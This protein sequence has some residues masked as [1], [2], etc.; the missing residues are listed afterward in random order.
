MPDDV[1]VETGFRLGVKEVRP[2]DVTYCVAADPLVVY[3]VEALVV[4]EY[5]G[6]CICTYC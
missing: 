1:T 4:Y 3:M 2:G 6:C 5:A